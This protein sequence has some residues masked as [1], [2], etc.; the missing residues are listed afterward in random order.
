MKRFLVAGAILFLS[1]TLQTVSAQYYFNNGRQYESAVTLEAGVSVG[2]MN[3]LSDLGG[4]KGIG[5][6]FIK[7][8][9]WKNS[10]PCAGIYLAANYQY[11]FVARLQGT[12]GSVTAYDSILKP[13]AATTT[14]RYERNLSFKSK[15][16]DFQLALELHPL[17]FKNYYARDEEPPYFSPYIVVGVG[18]FAFD[19][20]AKYNNQWYALQPLRTEGQGFKEYADRKPYKLNQF[21]IAGGIG[22]KFEVSSS[23]FARFEVNHR[24]LN[25]DYLDDASTGYID[26]SLFYNYLPANKAAIAQRLFD[27]RAEV[28]PT[29][30]TNY[31]Y[32]RGNPTDND[33]FFSIELKVGVTLGRQRR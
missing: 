27:R 4:K 3:C 32:Q 29:H 5:K 30:E 19:P 28:D 18:Y 16:A 15:I 26:P 9:N 20:K 1:F 12:F 10:R 14:G 25:T 7:D 23:V 13:I 17:F 33:A 21:N 11:L 8:L 22:V 31:G 6:N 24:F 2:V